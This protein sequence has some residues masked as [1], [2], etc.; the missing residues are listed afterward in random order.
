MIKVSVKF[1]DGSCGEYSR[2]S[3]FAEKILELQRQGYAGKKIINTS[4]TDNWES[5][6]KY[7]K[8]IGNLSNGTRIY[9]Q[10]SYK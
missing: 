3:D 9:S 6:P 1:V 8:I 4:I 5:L 10:I 2:N 7:V